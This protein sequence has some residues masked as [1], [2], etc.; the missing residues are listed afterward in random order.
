MKNTNKCQKNPLL[1]NVEENEKVIGNL[2]ADPD[3]HQ[4]ITSR[5]SPL[6]HACQVRFRVR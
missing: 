1:R 5:G 6:A 2:H 4:K 3:H